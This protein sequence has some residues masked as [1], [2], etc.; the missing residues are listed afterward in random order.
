MKPAIEVTSFCNNKCV[1]CPYQNKDIDK[2]FMDFDLFCSLVDVLAPQSEAINLFN[3]GEP[4]LHPKI[5][6][7]IAY[8][9]AKC[10]VILSTNG[11]FVDVDELYGVFHNGTLCVSLPAGTRETYE[12]LTKMDNFDLVVNKIIQLQDK[13]PDGVEMYVKMVKQPENAMED[14][15][16]RRFAKKVVVVDDSNHERGHLDCTQPDVTPV[17]RF[18][19]KKV[20]CCRDA[21]G[22]FGWETNYEAAKRRELPICV[23]CGI[24]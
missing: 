7:M 14:E 3:R 22:E 15:E 11:V 6:E 20:V 19:G 9:Q 17:W 21:K 5:Y 4:F 13:K 18:D 8:A 16:I 23:G 1:F 24:R 12:N 2:G 10:P